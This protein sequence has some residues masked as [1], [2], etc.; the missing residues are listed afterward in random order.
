L[1]TARPAPCGEGRMEVEK[2]KPELVDRLLAL[3]PR[4]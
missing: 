4:M 3:E 2:L 1:L